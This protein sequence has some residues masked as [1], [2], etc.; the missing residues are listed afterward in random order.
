MF[1]PYICIK[2]KKKEKKITETE[3]APHLPF[4]NAIAQSRLKITKINISTV[5]IF[6][7]RRFW[8][9]KTTFP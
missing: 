3:K 7:Q 8:S 6:S 1:F 2:K 5:K 4:E 9:F